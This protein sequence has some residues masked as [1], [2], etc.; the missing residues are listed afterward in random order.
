MHL[1]SVTQYLTGGT[2]TPREQGEK[3]LLIYIEGA[4]AD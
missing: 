4:T 1:E 3:P 2:E